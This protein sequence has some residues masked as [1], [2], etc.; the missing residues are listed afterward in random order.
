MKYD[1]QK[2]H[3]RS[4]RLKNYDYSQ[5]G[6][7]FITICTQDRECLFGKINNGLMHLNEIGELVK[8]EWLRT[9]EIRP[10]IIVDEFVIMPNHLHGIL[11]IDDVN[12]RV[13]SQC[14]PT[15][16]TNNN[17]LILKQPQY[18]QFGKSTKNS[19]PTI[20]KLFKSTTTKQINL[21]RKTPGQKVWQRNYY[22]HIIRDELELN[23]IRLYIKN[24]PKN[25][26]NDKNFNIY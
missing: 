7:Y 16:T 4:I 1:P 10:N 12:C 20:V 22:E 24:N 19:I 17:N 13:T 21:L 15:I 2:H 3:R 25:W 11:I 8:N 14:D 6:S 9:S 23:R 26:H 5:P 18:E